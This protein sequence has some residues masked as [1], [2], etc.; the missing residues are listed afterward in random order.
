MQDIFFITDIKNPPA[1][2]ERRLRRMLLGGW[3][4][5]MCEAIDQGCVLVLEKD[6]VKD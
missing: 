5:V 4:V 3:R 2:Q 6:F 1:D